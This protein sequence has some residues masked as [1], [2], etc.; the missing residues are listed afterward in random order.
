MDNS[1][2]LISGVQIAASLGSIV[3][4]LIGLY[5][6]VQDFQYIHPEDPAD[7][8]A[9]SKAAARKSLLM[10]ILGIALHSVGVI[11]RNLV[12]MA[13]QNYGIGVIIL[14]SMWEAFRSSALL[15]L[16]P[17]AIRLWRKIARRNN[18]FH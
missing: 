18:V 13:P 3:L 10:I 14:R 15:L 5:A 6:A 9:H 4:F 17:I 11:C 2:L 8:D 1:A 7:E 12:V 16:C